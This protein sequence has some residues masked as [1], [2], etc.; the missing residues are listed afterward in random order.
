MHISESR[1]ENHFYAHQCI[2]QSFFNVLYIKPEMMRSDYA[3]CY[4]NIKHNSL[5]KAEKD[6]SFDAQE[7]G[8]RFVWRQLFSKHMIEKHQRIQSQ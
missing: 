2:L 3:Q 6:D 5:P 1:K 8:K 4:K 7:L